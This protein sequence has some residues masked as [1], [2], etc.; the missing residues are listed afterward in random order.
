MERMAQSAF[1]LYASC[2]GSDG[3]ILRV[4]LVLRIRYE[5]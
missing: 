1:V 4:Y 3:I 5:Y 2:T